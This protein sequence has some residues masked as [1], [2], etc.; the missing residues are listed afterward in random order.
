M[1][2]NSLVKSRLLSDVRTE[3]QSRLP[4]PQLMPS[5]VPPTANRATYGG[6]LHTG[7]VVGSTSGRRGSPS[8]PNG[9]KAPR[10]ASS[11]SRTRKNTFFQTSLQAHGSTNPNYL[12]ALNGSVVILLVLRHHAVSPTAKARWIG[13]VCRVVMNVAV[14]VEIRP[15]VSNWVS[16]R[17]PSQLRSVWAV[18]IVMKARFRI[19]LSG[20]TKGDILLFVVYSIHLPCCLRLKCPLCFTTPR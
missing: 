4:S 15:L 8:D 18:A 11:V 10:N 13:R 12:K 6:T 14:K 2:V 19:E 3:R 20:G 5:A 7:C 17:K 1:I 9:T 16:G